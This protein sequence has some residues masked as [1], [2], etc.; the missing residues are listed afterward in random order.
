MAK[1]IRPHQSHREAHSGGAHSG[2]RRV[3][4]RVASAVLLVVFA[5][6][7]LAGWPAAATE[8]FDLGFDLISGV[9]FGKTKPAIVLRPEVK[10][11]SVSFVLERPDGR[12]IKLRAGAI[13]AGG[14]KRIPIPQGKG[15]VEYKATISG[16]A[17]DGPFGPFAMTFTVQV[18]AP[19]R[20]QIG[21]ADVDLDKRTITARS[22]EPAGKIT[23][24]IWGDDGNLIADIDQPMQGEKPGTPLV[25]TWPQTADQVAARF[26]LNVY[27]PV[28]F[29]TGIE[30]VTFVDIPHED[31]VFESGKWLVRP[32]EA[33]KLK[34][35]LS[36]I[37]AEL[38]KVE[39]ILPIT[40]YVGGYTDT[41]GS[42]DDNLE[43][44]RRR[45]LSIATWFRKHGLKCVIRYQ[46]FG[47]GVLFV[48]TADNVDEARNRRAAY[49]LS[50]QPPPPSR[51]FPT[52]R[53]ASVQ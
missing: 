7:T 6:A 14:E 1:D 17:A 34:E 21:P 33:A 36:R 48:E 11:R 46:G 30:S 31:I 44:S 16:K 40:L 13:R 42:V 39:G 15:I 53:W 4:R 18:G 2:A 35:P 10:I 29:Y 47:E 25:V 19:P 20:L 51:G 23:L 5:A 50:T 45:A 41:V 3:A 26:V 22:S 37:A 49:V 9:E 38:R 24:Q 28:G 8:P 32:E 27:D 43:L 52:S 12:K